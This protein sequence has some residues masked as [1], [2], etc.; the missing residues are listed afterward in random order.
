MASDDR[1]S[2]QTPGR[3]DCCTP[4]T[5][6]DAE[7]CRGMLLLYEMIRTGAVHK[8]LEEEEDEPFRQS[9]K[10]GVLKKLEIG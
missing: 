5:P 8:L 7:V 3:V 6:N 1:G 10:T 2:C 4:A 9:D